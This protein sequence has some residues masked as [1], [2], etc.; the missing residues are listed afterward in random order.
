MKR[1]PLRMSL[2]LLLCA[3]LGTLAAQQTKVFWEIGKAD[4]DTIEFALGRNRSNQYSVDFPRDALFIVGE[5]DP[6]QDWPYIQP[7]PADT[8]AGSKSHTFTILFGVKTAPGRG[9]CELLLDFVDTHSAKPPK[10]QIKIND[11]T[12]VRELPKGAGDPSAFGQVDKGREHRLTVEFPAQAIKAGTNA[13]TITSATGSWILYDYVALKTPPGIEAGPL[14]PIDKLLDVHT[15]PY[16]VEHADG[17]LYQPV[18]ASVL[19]V[20]EPVDATVAVNGAELV[21]PANP[22]ESGL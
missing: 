6:K 15:Q 17:K 19:H 13:I 11:A 21:I 16:L 18:R 22:S 10:M 5:S 3:S 14:E 7:G 12:F 4:N 9:N 1:S 2:L 8:W 20:G